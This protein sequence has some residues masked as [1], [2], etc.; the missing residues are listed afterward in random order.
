MMKFFE[1]IGRGI[2]LIGKCIGYIAMFI[3]L[4]CLCVI[5]FFAL[6]LVILI[7]VT[8]ENTT[9]Q[10]KVGIFSSTILAI[11][12]NYW[13]IQFLLSWIAPQ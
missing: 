13:W 9:E 11:A 5:G 3:G 2:E 8:P 4:C 12:L 6:P 1:L 7:S 10:A